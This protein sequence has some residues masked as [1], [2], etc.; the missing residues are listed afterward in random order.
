M[1]KFNSKNNG[2]E[3]EA[4]D[5]PEYK[6]CF[7]V[8]YLEYYETDPEIRKIINEHAKKCEACL[9]DRYFWISFDEEY[10]EVEDTLDQ[11]LR[12]IKNKE[13]I[14]KKIKRLREKNGP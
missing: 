4:Y 14:R 10:P 6:K 7:P 13:E 9:K 2:E 5:D 3:F 8:K 12:D 1:D 11:H